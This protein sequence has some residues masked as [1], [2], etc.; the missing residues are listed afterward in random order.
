MMKYK[1]VEELQKLLPPLTNDEYN[2]LRENIK[3]DGKINDPIILRKSD[4]AVLDGYHR[5]K[6]AEELQMTLNIETLDIKENGESRLWILKHARGQRNLDKVTIENICAEEYN[7][8]K[9]DPIEQKK[10][11]RAGKLTGGKKVNPEEKTVTRI[12]RKYNVSHKTVSQNVNAL[13][14][15]KYM[16]PDDLAAYKIGN[17]KKA[18]M[19]KIGMLVKSDKPELQNHIS[20]IK[21]M[22]KDGKQ[23]N[24]ISQEA[25]MARKMPDM[26][27]G[28]LEGTIKKQA[29]QNA[30]T[31]GTF[32]NNKP[33]KKIIIKVP[34]YE[35]ITNVHAPQE[36][37]EIQEILIKAIEAF[38]SQ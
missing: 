18:Y 36:P 28:Y 21:E 25:D 7:L 24:L 11:A 31:L 15:Q 4:G 34:P 14:A 5:I 38:L 1:E 6:I 13:E 23:Y 27:T 16:L 10:R 19:D 2:Q 29:M 26:Y 33:N 30:I 17:I 37:K 35:F 22:M 9:M 3:K 20:H 8:E 12:S 32:N